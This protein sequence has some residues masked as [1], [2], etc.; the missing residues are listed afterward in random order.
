MT[1]SVKQTFTCVPVL[2]QIMRSSVRFEVLRAV[3][4]KI[5]VFSK[6]QACHS[7]KLTRMI[8]FNNREGEKNITLITQSSELV[9]EEKPLSGKS[10]NLRLN[11]F[12]QSISYSCLFKVFSAISLLITVTDYM[13][14]IQ[15]SQ[16][17]I[18]C[19]I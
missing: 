12:E 10:I 19:T 9:S 17:N 11:L 6:N 5:Q 13:T 1:G 16:L 4:I 15:E 3:F 8:C 18:N 7:V 14:I 2:A